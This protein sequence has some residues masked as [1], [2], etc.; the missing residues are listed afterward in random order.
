[1]DQGSGGHILAI[2]AGVLLLLAFFAPVVVAE[3]R[4][5]K[6]LQG[7]AIL[8]CLLSAIPLLLSAAGMATGGFLSS[9]ILWPMAASLWF[10]GL[11][12]GLA[13]AI[14]RALEHHAKTS[15][16]LLL[17]GQEMEQDR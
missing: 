15:T 11:F 17:Q 4:R 3:A 2:G 6:S 9:V 14:I 13:A 16:R 8:F 1:M 7:F 10:A 5:P 12:C